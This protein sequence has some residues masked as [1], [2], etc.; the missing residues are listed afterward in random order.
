[1][2][3]FRSKNKII[4]LGILLLLCGVL[5]Y[6]CAEAPRQKTLGGAVGAGK[7]FA[8]KDC[9]DCHK[10]FVDKYLGMKN[11]HKVVKEKKCE[12]CHF[13]HG[14]VPKLILKKEGNE[15]CYPCHNR[16][17]IGLSK[18]NVHTALKR[19][20]CPKNRGGWSR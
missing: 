14:L 6:A 11:V 2:Y 3:L 17:K 13:R 18:P 5:L 9:L 16:E 12:D 4:F 20:R 7:R 10:K 1:M 8:Q 19:G 15:I